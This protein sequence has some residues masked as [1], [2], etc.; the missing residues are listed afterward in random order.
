MFVMT[1]NITIG[2]YSN[3]KPHAVNWKCSVSNFVDTCKIKLPLTTSLQPKSSETIDAENIK[4][5]KAR[6]SEGDYVEVQLGYNSLNSKRFC[7]FI[8]K[9]N[10]S[11]PMEIDCEGFSY[12]LKK[13]IFT[14][15]YAST[16]IVDILTDLIGSEGIVLS[17]AIPHVPLKNVSF[18]NTPGLKVLEWF[19]KEC[20][21]TV[22]FDFD[23][24]YVGPSKYAVLKDTVDLRL[25]WNTIDEKE[26]K[27]ITE[28]KF[29]EIHIVTKNND[30]EVQKTK[31]ENKKYDNVKE[32][33]VR[34]GLTESFKNTLRNELQ[35]AENYKGYEGN[36]LLFLEPVIEKSSAVYIEDT[37]YGER[38]GK[39]FCETVEGSFDKS[40]GRQKIY[41]KYYANN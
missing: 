40:G 3:V 24:L 4:Q 36:V 19:Q 34:S 15:S 20:L 7:G 33:K 10:Y 38:E 23:T 35:N 8:D 32:V 29:T 13:K 5:L 1:S 21:C 22:F 31:S 12:L 30:G 39:F 28:Q 2:D 14:K 9:I 26:L 41:L 37:K 6:F 18:K 11:T 16:T 17:T 25:S 27:R